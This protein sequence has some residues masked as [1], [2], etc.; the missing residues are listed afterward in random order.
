MN[1][2]SIMNKKSVL[3]FLCMF[4]FMHFQNTI[5]FPPGLVPGPG[6]VLMKN[7]HGQIVLVQQGAIAGQQNVS[8]VA[9]S[10]SNTPHKVQ[11]V[12]V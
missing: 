3:L 11:Y 4:M 1:N 5:T 10:T 9:L 6:A 7:E 12:R 2:V 8:S